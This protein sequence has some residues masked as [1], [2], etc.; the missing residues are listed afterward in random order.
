GAGEFR[1][2]AAA[3]AQGGRGAVF[4][5]AA[6]E[7]AR[8]FGLRPRRRALPL[9]SGNGSVQHARGRPAGQRGPRIRTAR[10]GNRRAVR[11]VA[12]APFAWAGR[13][14]LAALDDGAHAGTGLPE[15]AGHG[16][17]LSAGG[18]RDARSGLAGPAVL[19]GGGEC[20]SPA[21]A[22]QRKRRARA[23]Y[24]GA[25]A[26]RSRRRKLMPL[27]EGAPGMTRG[28]RFRP[29]RIRRHLVFGVTA[30]SASP[31]RFD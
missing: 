1:R 14:R 11:A 22:G 27:K 18:A 29:N 23:G 31:R 5:A 7:Y 9:D 3:P 26:G 6:G 20:R 19:A 17:L 2:G 16:L 28:R 15:S 10:G 25:F 30:Y 24:V 4:D 21:V 13:G 8:A 12:S